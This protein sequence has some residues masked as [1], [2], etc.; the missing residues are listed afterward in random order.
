MDSQDCPCA[1]GKAAL[2][3]IPGG[4]GSP[5]IPAG[6]LTLPPAG[7]LRHS[8][9]SFSYGLG[10]QLKSFPSTAVSH[11][12]HL[13]EKRLG[14]TSPLSEA[15]SS[16]DARRGSN[17]LPRGSL[18]CGYSLLPPLLNLFFSFSL[19]FR[20]HLHL[21]GQLQM[22]KLQMHIV[23]KR[24]LLLL[25]SWMCQVCTGLRLQGASL[26]QVQLLQIGDPWLH[27]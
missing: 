17:A 23:Q 3:S 6:T 5:G 16:V 18:S 26:R 12:E 8:R 21:R 25:P 27:I 24:L 20:W 4:S 7:L 15:E 13:T 14:M 19:C 11:W 9:C 2:P 1:T 10:Q 22:Q